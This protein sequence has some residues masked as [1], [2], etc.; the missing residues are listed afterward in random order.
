LN[1]GG[2]MANENKTTFICFNNV[3][4]GYRDFG[5][6]I[7]MI[8]ILANNKQ[9]LTYLAPFFITIF[10]VVVFN[11]VYLFRVYKDYISLT[12]NSIIINYGFKK[13]VVSLSNIG[14]VNYSKNSIICNMIDGSQ[15][16]IDI[17]I[18]STLK[19]AKETARIISNE[20]KLPFIEMNE[21]VEKFVGVYEGLTRE[22]AKNQYPLMGETNSPEGSETLEKRVHKVLY[23][24]LYK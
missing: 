2:L 20:M 15:N 17:I 24:I 3:C 11:C 16:R 7:L 14:S 10:A 22:E 6:N 19:R 18:S 12:D 21:L 5:V 8:K 13:K 1:D 23:V 9:F 4:C